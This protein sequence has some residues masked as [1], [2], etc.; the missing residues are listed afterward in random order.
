MEFFECE[1]EEYVSF[2]FSERIIEISIAEEKYI[3]EDCG[4][5]KG[6]NESSFRTFASSSIKCLVSRNTSW[7]LN[8]LDRTSKMDN[9]PR[10]AW[11]DR[12]GR[13]S[14]NDEIIFRLRPLCCLRASTISY[15]QERFPLI[16]TIRQFRNTRLNR[17]VCCNSIRTHSMN[18]E[19]KMFV[20]HIKKITK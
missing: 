9:A 15:F 2:F 11:Y 19:K 20:H 12:D 4:K 7:T 8:T 5:K 17:F 13:I 18:S 16:R 1:R 3:G 10:N 6:K 14:V